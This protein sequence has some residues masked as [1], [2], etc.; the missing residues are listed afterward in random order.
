MF[1]VRVIQRFVDMKIQILS[2]VKPG[3]ACLI[4]LLSLVALQAKQPS[5]AFFSRLQEEQSLTTLTASPPPPSRALAA[6]AEQ[7]TFGTNYINLNSREVSRQFFNLVYQASAGV[8]MD[9]SGSYA[10]SNPGTNSTAYLKATQR[11]INY[12]RAMAGVPADISFDP[13]LN[14]YCQ[15]AALMMG[16]SNA[17]SQTPTSDWLYFTPQGANAALY[18][19]LTLSFTG[20]DAITVQMWENGAN[21]NFNYP[22]VGDRRW[23]LFPQTL[24]MG[25]GNVPSISPSNSASVLWAIENAALLRTR[26][27]TRNGFVSWPPPGYVPYQ[28]VYPRWSFSYPNADFTSAEVYM[29]SNSTALD[30][31]I[32]PAVPNVGENTLVWYPSSLNVSDSST[33]FFKPTNDTIYSI[34]LSNVVLGGSNITVSYQVTVFDPAV[35][36]LDYFPPTLTGALR[37]LVAVSNNYA[38]T[39]VANA[40][41]YDY[42]AS[43]L[44]LLNLFDGAE[45]SPT[46]WT[47]QAATNLYPLRDSITRSSGTASY[48]LCHIQAAQQYMTFTNSLFIQTNSTFLFDSRLNY[49]NTNQVAR[50]QISTNNG[51]SWK[52]VYTQL[53]AGL[54]IYGETGFSQ[55][56]VSLGTYAGLVLQLRL[57]YTLS[58]GNYHDQADS[59]VGWHIDN[60]LFTNFF[61]LSLPTTATASTN[62][63]FAFI[64]AST[65]RYLLEV[66]PILFTDYAGPF[67][68]GLILNPGPYMKMAGG[69]Q[70]NGNFQFDF[71]VTAT[72]SGGFEVWSAPSLTNAFVK[73][74]GASI[75]TI[76]AD[77]QYRATVPTNGALR[78]YRVQA[79]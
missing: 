37:P 19:N 43:A 74:T 71:T 33:T 34:T 60:L 31:T 11:R 70:T 17:M 4:V 22:S 79:P 66:R 45:T 51:V 50:V 3:L 48:H 40:Y 28:V 61:S 76:V 53:G 52:D 21:Y 14:S 38:F 12:F 54:N 55:R 56:T 30:I 49:A 1:V 63:T 23:L 7:L 9:W 78:I 44:A 13:T 24:T 73:E 67:G 27:P 39:A 57:A 72:N 26:P 42:R 25:V 46:N 35:P 6:Y 36:G 62:L 16:A 69:Q 68:P 15:A 58:S 65:N 59:D 10:T 18:A 29:K 41:G 32:E 47:I 8:P 2:A 5:V 64:P 75:Q 20:P 77:A